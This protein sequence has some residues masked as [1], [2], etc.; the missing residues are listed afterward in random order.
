MFKTT[1]F[2]SL[3]LASIQMSMANELNY[4][5]E[6]NDRINLGDIKYFIQ[7]K[8]GANPKGNT[9]CE[10][11]IF[12]N[13]HFLAVFDGATDKSGKIYESER[14]G[15]RVARDIIIEVFKSLPPEAQKEDIL[16]LINKKYQVFYNAHPDIDF[17]NNP[18]FRPTATLIWYSFH[19]KEMVAIGDSKARIDGKIYN[20]ESKM[21][22][23][24]NSHLRVKV[25]KELNLTDKEIAENDLGRF[26]ILPLLEKQSE[27]QNNPKAPDAFQFWAID[28]FEVPSDKLKVWKF[29]KLPQII[30]LSSDGYE[31][32]PDEVSIKAYESELAK[33]LKE[34]PMRI[35]NPSTKGLQKDNASF[36][37]RAILI[38]QAKN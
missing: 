7:G 20:N 25:I 3:F 19:H 8:A 23:I 35:H 30:E 16:K 14:K 32:I 28:G 12:Y 27:F 26:Y 22:D 10:D 18:L 24:L 37:D 21:V 34:D 13:N 9:N 5:Q 4:N 11:G 2:I 17:K 33:L 6:I 15:G 31:T 29:E 1:I 38:F 36:D